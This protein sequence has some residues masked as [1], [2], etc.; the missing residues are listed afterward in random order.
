MSA[1]IIMIIIIIIIIIEFWVSLRC[2]TGRLDFP[3]FLSS[4][5][6]W[7][8]QRLSEAAE[9]SHRRPR[10]PSLLLL[11]SALLLP[12]PSSS[13]SSLLLPLPSSSSSSSSK[14]RV[15]ASFRHFKKDFNFSRSLW[16]VT[17]MEVDQSQWRLVRFTL[18]WSRMIGYVSSGRHG[19]MF[20]FT[21]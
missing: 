3:Q 19:F 7:L 20:P 16:P 11:P 14:L 10:R 4:V 18:L 21:L 5:P 12:L 1:I 13:S 6:Q 17:S 8:Q 2:H 9:T 15:D